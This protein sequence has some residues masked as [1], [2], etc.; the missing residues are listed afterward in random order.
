[1]LVALKFRSDRAWLL[2][3]I[4]AE[5]IALL[6]VLAHTVAVKPGAPAPVPDVRH[7]LDL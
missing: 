1:V 5:G 7:L 3:P 6:T 2:V 4:I